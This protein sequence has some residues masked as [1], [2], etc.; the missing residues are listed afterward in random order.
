MKFQTLKYYVVMVMLLVMIF[1][2]VGF[3]GYENGSGQVDINPDFPEIEEPEVPEN[4][5]E[6]EVVEMPKFNSWN[7]LWEY[8]YNILLE[9]Y[10]SNFSMNVNANTLGTTAIQSFSGSEIYNSVLNQ[11]K[12]EYF[13]TNSNSMA[14]ADSTYY[15]YMT[16]KDNICEK[17]RTND[18]NYEEKTYNFTNEPITKTE[19][20]EFKPFLFCLRGLE[21]TKENV[22]EIL[23]DKV[24]NSSYYIIKLE[25]K[26]DKLTQVYFDSFTSTGLVDSVDINSIN[27][28]IRI[29]KKNGSLYS[30]KT[31]ENYVNHLSFLPLSA[32]CV[33]T[34]I[35]IFQ[36]E[37]NPVI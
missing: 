27:F 34:A 29:S 10:T 25:Y 1:C 32:N 23:F 6:D 31:I 9:G 11:A 33:S 18:I 26:L 7:K 14:G 24:S 8:S 37:K 21:L 22:N 2:V 19:V 12:L 30:I 28:E 20:D 16:Y 35:Q 4:P 3:T 13:T 17:R 36:V 5:S 15:E